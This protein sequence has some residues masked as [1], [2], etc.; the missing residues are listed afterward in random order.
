MFMWESLTQGIMGY[1][2]TAAVR[3]YFI[4]CPVPLVSVLLF[5]IKIFV[6]NLGFNKKKKKTFVGL[7]LISRV[8]I[9]F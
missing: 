5:W 8:P 4:K 2:R 9:K 1:V 3:Q 7:S 6:M